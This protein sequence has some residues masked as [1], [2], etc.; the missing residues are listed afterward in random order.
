MLEV[1]L[2]VLRSY[3]NE[4]NEQIVQTRTELDQL[5]ERISSLPALESELS[6][7]IRD[8]KIQ[9]QLYLLLT[10]E[11]EQARIRETMDTPTVQVLDVA[12]PPERPS[13]P[14]R[15]ILTL[16]AGILGFSVAA[17]AIL[18]REGSAPRPT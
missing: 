7:L 17:V 10:S 2:G 16:A 9:E 5:K 13:R 4:D 11:L 8:Q 3:L 18:V 6:R 15:L 1:R 12:V 14:R